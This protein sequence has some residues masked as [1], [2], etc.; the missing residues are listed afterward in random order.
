MIKIYVTGDNHFGRK[1]DRY[2]DVKDQ[3]IESRFTTLEGMVRKA[4]IEGCEFFVITG[5]LFD[6][7]NTVK[8]SDVKRVV[9]ILAEFAGCVIIL[10]GNHDYFT[11]EEKVWKD[12]DHTL[13]LVDHNITVIHRFEPYV[14]D[15][16]EEKVVFYPAFCQ[17]KHSKK[18]NLDWIKDADIQKEGVINIGLAHGAIQGITPDM[19]EEYFLMTENELLGVSMDVWLIGHTHIPYPNDLKEDYDIVQYKIFNAGTHEQTDLHNNT[20][21]NGFI[22]SIE[23]EGTTVKVLAK[24]HISGKIHFFDMAI[25]VSPHSEEAL[26]NAIKDAVLAKNKHAVLRI[27]V[28]GSIKQIEYLEKEK[29]YKEILGDFLTYEINDSELSEEI[30]VDKI[31]DEF[32]ETSFAAR[33][34]EELIDSPTE[35]QMAYQL[36]QSCREE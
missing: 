17:S 9:N 28:S 35:L 25:H 27:C 6:N 26:S 13:S 14:F 3:L 23:K 33:F 30:T 7:I 32:A 1:Y 21:G 19:K 10:P 24:K 2:P 31:R 22:L 8:L 29:I 36:L 4:E 5:D 20:D 15:T 18:N 16:S 12:F 34:M 11:G